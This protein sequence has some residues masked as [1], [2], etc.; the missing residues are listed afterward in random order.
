[1]GGWIL[2][3]LSRMPGLQSLFSKLTEDLASRQNVIVLLPAGISTDEIW[4]SLRSELFRLSFK[5]EGLLLPGLQGG[6]TAWITLAQALGVEM[7]RKTRTLEA[8]LTSTGLPDV[9]YLSGIEL[10]PPQARRQWMQV[11]ARWGEI[12]QTVAVRRL[13]TPTLCMIAPAEAILDWIPQDN[14]KLTIHWWWDVTS[15]LELQLLYR[16]RNGR[17]AAAGKMTW[18]EY[19]LPDLAGADVGFAEYLWDCAW[20]SFETFC[21]QAAALGKK[22][23]WTADMFRDLGAEEFLASGEAGKHTT[24]SLPP[25]RWRP[26]WAVGGMFSTQEHGMELSS[27]TLAVLGR[28]DELRHRLWRGQATLMLPLID[29]VRLVLCNELIRH[30]GYEWP[31]RWL[32]PTS[33]EEARAIKENPLACQWGYLVESLRNNTAL[34]GQ[35]QWLP[36]ALA[37]HRLRNEMAHYRPVTY[38]SF[39]GFLREIE[40]VSRRLNLN[41]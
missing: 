17:N 1:M 6:D 33:P 2:S 39:I 23:G 9:I 8:L 7:S 36:L 20:G 11:A 38:E 12:S 18:R 27:V 10:L 30:C 14:V 31:S 22:R 13:T 34:R 16:L 37:A 26:L 35:R 28:T 29:H 4:Q 24:G 25:V 3:G 15:A 19:L 41:L 21:E 32:P 5:L 40:V